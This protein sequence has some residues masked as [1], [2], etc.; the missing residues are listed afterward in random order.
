MY[1]PSSVF[2]KF[3]QNAINGSDSKYNFY[4]LKRT[5]HKTKWKSRDVIINLHIKNKKFAKII[6][7][8][9]R[10]PWYGENVANTFENKFGSG[11]KKE[12]TDK[13]YNR[14]TNQEGE[15]T[16]SG[17]Q[18]NYTKKGKEENKFLSGNQ[19]E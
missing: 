9:E 6:V 16:G 13:F 14:A 19:K 1:S 3:T 11:T 10:R 7:D 15:V 18:D 12:T 17:C 8:N 4:H 5:Y 2:I